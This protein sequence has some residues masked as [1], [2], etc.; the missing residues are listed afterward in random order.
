MNQNIQ[1]F[2]MW[3]VRAFVE[4]NDGTVV[5]CGVADDGTPLILGTNTPF[6]DLTVTRTTATQDIPK[7]AVMYIIQSPEIGSTGTQTV[8][9]QV[10]DVVSTS[11]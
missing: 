5:S 2:N 6:V 9:T 8:I 3:D 7:T 10:V 4:R 1:Q 11:S